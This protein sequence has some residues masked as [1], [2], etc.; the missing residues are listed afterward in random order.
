[1]QSQSLLEE[2]DL[3]GF[4]ANALSTAQ[5]VDIQDELNRRAISMGDLRSIA[6]AKGMN[7][8]EFDALENRLLGLSSS[9]IQLPPVEPVQKTN[10][11][12]H[13]AKKATG[14]NGWI[15][16][17]EI[18]SNSALSFEPNQTLS[19]PSAYVLGVGDELEV[20]IHGIQQF[21]QTARVNRQGDV[22]LTNIG[23]VHV[24]GLQVGAASEAIRRKASRIYST[25]GSGRS[26]LSVTISEF[27]SIQVTMIGVKQPGNYT[28]SSLSTVFNALHV[29]GGPSQ[30]GSYRKIELIRNNKRFMV[31][32]LYKFLTE[33][34]LSQNIALQQDDIIRVPTF[35]TRVTIEGC[36]KRPGV[37]ELLEGEGFAELLEYCSG[38]A[39]NAYRSSIQ[40]KTSTDSEMKINTVAKEHFDNIQLKSGDVL[41]VG[42][43]LKTFENKVRISGAVYRPEDYE[44]TDGMR[45]SDLLSAADGLKPDAFGERALLLRKGDQLVPEIIGVNIL[46]ILEDPNSEENKELRKDD[47]LV[48]SSVLSLKEELSVNIR[49]EVQMPGEYKFVQNMTLYDLIILSGGFSEF[50]SRK[51]EI[52]RVLKSD[53]FDT[54]GIESELISF[55]ITPDYKSGAENIML[56]PLDYVSIRKVQNY[57]PSQEVLVSGEVRYPGTYIISKDNE[58]IYDILERAG[59]LNSKANIKGVKITRSQGVISSEDPNTSI[60]V[61]PVDYKKIKKKPQSK[62][63]IVVRRGDHVFVERQVNTASISGAVELSTEIPVVN[64][65]GVRY[66][67]NNAG[68]FKEN[69]DKKR[70]Y[71]R[72]AN[73]SA[74]TTTRFLG[75]KFYPK[76]EE[77]AVIVVPAKNMDR[78]GMSTQDVIA[79]SSVLSSISGITIAVI[80][81]MK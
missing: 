46:N 54:T 60:S 72:Y 68:G 53:E 8:M 51:V 14:N 70:T 36:V 40:I 59:G 18:F 67:V 9:N 5:L 26:E 2:F 41:K 30:T 20:A 55:E 27:K 62:A 35:D 74:K 39:D 57:V 56:K 48:V 19:N 16:G 38:F 42:E 47:E 13:S 29:S 45:I 71:V 31:I 34:D 69:A 65:K 81:L 23:A 50:A 77:G 75:I 61:I 58:R 25:L 52:A 78:K 33:G 22:V 49:G 76:V 15:F 79:L 32:D 80:S 66:Y 12:E 44:L 10:A 1:V 37:F 64:G 3:S 7:P 17:S 11:P 6:I 21:L 4:S 28:L 73:G 63:N 43:I 24:S